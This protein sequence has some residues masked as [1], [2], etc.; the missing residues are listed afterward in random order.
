[1]DL[2]FGLVLGTI[3]YYILVNMYKH[4]VSD[5]VIIKPCTNH[6]WDRDEHDQLYC[7]TCK[8]SWDSILNG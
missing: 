1:M 5:D 3:I 6:T 7:T 8:K 4:M 2:I